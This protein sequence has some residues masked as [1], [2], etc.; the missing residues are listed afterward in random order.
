MSEFFIEIGIEEVPVAEIKPASEYLAH[1]IKHMLESEHITFTMIKTYFTPRRL[2]LC[3]EGLS[4]KGEPSLTTYTGPRKEA[5]F[6]KDGAPTQAAIGF[7][8][9]KGMDVKLLKTVKLDKGEFI[10]VEIKKPGIQTKSLINQNLEKLILGVPFRKSMRWDSESI[11]FIR[12]IRW[13]A[14]LYNGK[15]IP[16]SI[17]MVKAS[18]YTYGLRTG[19]GKKIKITKAKSP[20]PPFT[21]GGTG[22]I[23]CLNAWLM[24]MK[25]ERILPEFEE[26]RNKIK[27]QA[28]VLAKKAGGQA[29]PDVGLLETITNLVESPTAI[30]GSFDKRFMN[31]PE[32]VIMSVMKTHQKYIPIMEKV[33]GSDMG[34]GELM[35][36]FIGISNNPYGDKKIIRKGYERVL[37]ARLEDAEFYYHQDIKQPLESYIELL[38]GMMFYPKLGSLYDK[39]E[40]IVTISSY[41]CDNT[42]IHDRLFDQK[43]KDIAIKASSL[44]KADLATRLVSEFPEL[45]GIIGHHY[46]LLK[47][48]SATETARAVTEQYSQP[49]RIPGAV[50]YIADK[51]DSLVGFGS[52]NEIPTGN[53]DPYGLRRAAI[54]I[55]NA[56][57]NNDLE[58]DIKKLIE[59]TLDRSPN[60]SILSDKV[61]LDKQWVLSYI[62]GRLE[63]ILHDRFYIDESLAAMLDKKGNPIDK[64]IDAVIATEPENI[65]DATLRIDELKDI[66]FTPDFEPIFLAFKRVINISKN[67]NPGEIISMLL[68]EPSELALYDRYLEVEPAIKSALANRDYTGY[69]GWIQKLVE[70][71]NTFFDKVLVM[72]DDESIKNNRLNLLAKIKNLVMQILDISKLL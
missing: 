28:D 4:D 40:R 9:S 21:K 34:L 27:E 32:E 3:V 48:P 16:V 36:Y 45:Q 59:F 8:R 72:S 13:L 29:V 6:D 24:A 2:A 53:Q 67:R 42:K 31:L 39:T 14:V 68:A 66:V 61:A 44:C 70:P 50:V 43:T 26:R 64:L 58:L 38:K 46:I 49:T 11:S 15:V 19:S 30:R 5:A 25:K 33:P 17:G 54:G 23:Y 62:Y 57:L 52:I 69:I 60:K 71:I 35:P 56:I 1:N 37:H 12:P 18:S 41:L 20:L 7:A 55:I 51:I 22:G 63:G 47:D 65:I 10:Q